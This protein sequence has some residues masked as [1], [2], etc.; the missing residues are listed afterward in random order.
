MPRI[1]CT[2]PRTRPRVRLSFRE[3]RITFGEATELHRKSGM[4]G[5]HRSRRDPMG[6]VIK[7][8]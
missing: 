1:S 5:T 7:G 2:L 4:W 8:D 3:R 6:C